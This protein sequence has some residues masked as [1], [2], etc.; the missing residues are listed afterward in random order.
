MRLVILALLLLILPACHLRSSEYY[1]KKANKLEEE[2]KYKEAVE[3]LDLA[4]ERNPENIKALLD[5]GA[6]KSMLKDYKG[7]IKDYSQVTKIDPDN[8]L[9]LYNSGLNKWRLDDFAESI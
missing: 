3:F 5:R 8:T 7:A 4:V 2:K 6:D 9:A 1:R